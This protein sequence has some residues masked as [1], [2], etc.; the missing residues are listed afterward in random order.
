MHKY[1]S[2]LVLPVMGICL[3]L[4]SG[5]ALG[6]LPV[7]KSSGQTA[8]GF[9]DVCKTPLPAGAPVPT[10]YPNVVEASR[11]DYAA[12]AERTKEGDTIRIKN[13]PLRTDRGI[14]VHG[15][16]IEVLGRDGRQKRLTRSTLLPLK[17]GSY[18]AVCVANGRITRI[19]KLR[20]AV[21]PARATIVR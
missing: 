14:Q 13:V 16:A 3:S 19:L 12:G 15:F 8:A 6:M 11:S 21:A 5:N 4:A 9:P 20:P 17:D 1:L 10:P 2:G 7:T 18:C